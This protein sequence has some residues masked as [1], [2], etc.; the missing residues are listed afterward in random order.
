MF[1]YL[2]LIVLVY[3]SGEIRV[4]SKLWQHRYARYYLEL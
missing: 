2:C 1:L 4:S 3:E